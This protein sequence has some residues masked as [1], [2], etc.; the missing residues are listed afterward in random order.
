MPG[1][2]TEFFPKS[3]EKFAYPNGTEWQRMIKEGIFPK[4]DEAELVNS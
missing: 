2:S 4:P 3:L 1:Y